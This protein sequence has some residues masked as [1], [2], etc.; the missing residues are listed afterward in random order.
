MFRS[1]FVAII[2]RPNSGKSTLLNRVIG[3]HLS[4]VTFKAQ[5]TQRQIRGIHQDDN[6]QMILVDT[7][8]IHTAKEGGLNECLVKEAKRA[9]EAPDVIWYLIDPDSKMKRE[10]VVLKLLPNQDAKIFILYNKL[11]MAQFQHKEELIASLKEKN[12]TS[13]EEREISA[14]H[15]DGVDALVDETMALLPEHPA[16]YPDSEALS[17]Q[18]VRFFIGEKIRRHLFLNLGEE[19]PYS[20]AV[21]I[22]KMEDAPL[23]RIEAVIHVERKSQKPM[24]IGRKGQKIK[25]IGTDAR[26]EI[27]EFLGKKVFLGLK[28]DILENWTRNRSELERLGYFVQ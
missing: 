13:I 7:P 8:G 22:Q 12:F 18:P 17:D 27:E 5:T 15:G 3:N 1:G 16:Y 11:D 4:P 14:K 2:G 24:V 25:E 28:V 6:G 9:V 20:C 10:E 21:E 23:T 26:K 19:L